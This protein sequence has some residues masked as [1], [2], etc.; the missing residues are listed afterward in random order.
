MGFHCNTLI[1]S[2]W[3]PSARRGE[4]LKSHTFVVCSSAFSLA[5]LFIALL[6]EFL[7]LSLLFFVDT[8]VSVFSYLSY[9][10]DDNLTKQHCTY[11]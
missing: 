3:L 9:E 7:L 2:V 1:Y 10:G 6:I 11:S 5:G 4:E 8:L